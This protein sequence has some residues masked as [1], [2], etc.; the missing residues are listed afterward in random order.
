MY[1]ARVWSCL[2]HSIS[3]PFKAARTIRSREIPSVSG[4]RRW[5]AR[6]SNGLT[7]AMIR[8]L[9]LAPWCWIFYVA[10]ADHDLVSLKVSMNSIKSTSVLGAKTK[11]IFEV[12]TDIRIIDIIS[13]Q[14]IWINYGI[15]VSTC[16]IR[17]I[18]AKRTSPLT[19]SLIVL[20]ITVR[21]FP[22]SHDDAELSIF[23]LEEERKKLSS[24][25]SQYLIYMQAP[26]FAGE[27]HC[28]CWGSWR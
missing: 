21:G 10:Q 2:K 17:S 1:T 9:A 3:F 20:R 5:R 22:H 26:W 14:I 18:I 28:T 8:S 25:S 6:E 19:S 12:I 16:F 23:K 15:I 11:Q 7:H 4:A 24:N 13:I 27:Q